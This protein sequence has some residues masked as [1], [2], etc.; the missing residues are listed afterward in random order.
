MDSIDTVIIGAGVVGLALARE[1][2]LRVRFPRSVSHN[3]FI[4]ATIKKK[5]GS[6]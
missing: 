5:R 3:P 4:P 6:P 2:A 1:C